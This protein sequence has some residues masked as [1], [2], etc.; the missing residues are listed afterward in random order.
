MKDCVRAHRLRGRERYVRLEHPPGHAKADP[1]RGGGSHRDGSGRRFI[2]SPST[3]RSATRRTFGRAPRRRPRRGSTVT[4]TRFRSPGR[5]PSAPQGRG[6]N[7]KVV[8]GVVDR[9]DGGRARHPPSRN[10]EGEGPRDASE[11]CDQPETPRTADGTPGSGANATDP[12]RHAEHGLLHMWWYPARTIRRT[13]AVSHSAATASG[14]PLPGAARERFRE[15]RGPTASPNAA[16]PRRARRKTLC[17]PPE[18][19]AGEH[20]SPDPS[21]PPGAARAHRE[22]AQPATARGYYSRLGN[23]CKHYYILSKWR[24]MLA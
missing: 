13:L 24:G 22:R 2:S 14:R 17:D 9:S 5:S 6:A 20:R 19:T 1:R 18:H 21:S 3:C 4:Y 11:V 12:V 7:Q 8:D 15:H 10:A 23:L 16:G